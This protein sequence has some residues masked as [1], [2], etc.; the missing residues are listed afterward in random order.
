ML[1][2]G[3]RLLG[4][5]RTLLRGVLGLYVLAAVLMPLG[6]HDIACHLKSTTHCSTCVVGS[7]AE[8]PSHAGPLAGL[9]LDDAGAALSTAIEHLHDERTRSSSGR[10]PPLT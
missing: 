2:S 4:A 8:S 7:S 9:G 5:R 3:R 6:H 1:R 10:S